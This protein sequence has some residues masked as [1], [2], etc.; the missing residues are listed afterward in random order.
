MNEIT[1]KIVEPNIAIIQLN[2]PE[3]RNILN[4]D[5]LKSI[6]S[7]L[8]DFK[9][10]SV[11][12]AIITGEGNSFSAGYD[13]SKLR[14]GFS[15]TSKLSANKKSVLQQATETVESLPF[16][17]IA[18]IRGFCIGAGF[19]LASS[20]DFRIATKS[21]RFGITPANIGL[22]YP[23]SGIKRVIR[24]VGETFARELFFTGNIFSA[25]RMYE[26]GFLNYIVDEDELYDFTLN[27]ARD[28]L[29]NSPTSIRYMKAEFSTLANLYEFNKELMSLTENSLNSKDIE[30][31]MNAFF[32]KRK[33]AF[34]GD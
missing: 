22:V 29:E 33:P 30:E 12:C 8:D 27:F 6:I 21:S 20:C 15:V 7:H 34:K 5:F 25:E 14:E 2:N 16:P 19:D 9:N 4:A 18:M 28:L 26:R 24:L 10:Q 13:I 31:G 32:E 23:S 11:R 17:V 3:K 1:G